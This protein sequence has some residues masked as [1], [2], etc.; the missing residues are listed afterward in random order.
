MCIIIPKP[1]PSKIIKIQ[2]R[3]TEIKHFTKN[4]YLTQSRT[5]K[6]EQMN[7]TYEI[8]RKITKVVNKSNDISNII[9][10]E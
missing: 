7:K 8:Y 5:V 6:E 9:K 10:C 2:S 1:I 3:N 4:I